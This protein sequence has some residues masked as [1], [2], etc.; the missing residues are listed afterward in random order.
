[1]I[2]PK[3][4]EDL[5][6]ALTNLPGIGPKTAQ[7]LAFH[8]LKSPKEEAEKLAEAIIK[9]KTTIFYCK[10]CFNL[11]ENALC[12]I[13][14]DLKRDK[15]TICVVEE[16][17]DILAI[18]KTG[19]YHGLY[20]VLLG[21]ISPLEG[22]TPQDLKIKELISRVG[23]NKIKEIILATDSDPEG[24]TTAMYLLELLKPLG[25]KI[26]RIAFGIPVGSSLEYSDRVTL[27]KALE[28]RREL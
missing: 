10:D 5:I 23:L 3:T 24:E 12:P 18:E 1:M 20:H 2:Y 22:I 14:S 8:I 4:V 17:R 27:G 16:P 21:A 28:G 19:T 26:T 13:C 25:I 7:R 6:T 15:E 9:T 11:S